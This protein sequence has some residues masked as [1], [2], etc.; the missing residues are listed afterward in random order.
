[1]AAAAR[2]DTDRAAGTVTFTIPARALGNPATHAGTRL[3]INT[4]D[5]DGGYRPLGPQAQSA[6]FGGGNGASDPLVLDDTGVM[7]MPA[8][9]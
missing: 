5:Y 9:R 3:Y 8:V 2:I 4:W 7:E 1:M 6:S